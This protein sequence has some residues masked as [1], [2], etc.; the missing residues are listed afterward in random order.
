QTLGMR[1]RTSLALITALISASACNEAAETPAGANAV[2]KVSLRV[3]DPSDPAQAVIIQWH[4]SLLANDF[5]EFFEVEFRTPQVSDRMIRIL[6]DGIRER[7]VPPV[8]LSSEAPKGV[9][10]EGFRTY[11]LVGCIR[12]S[13]SSGPVRM[14]SVVTV[15]NIGGQWKVGGASFGAPSTEYDGPCPMQPFQKRE[16]EAAPASPHAQE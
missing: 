6:F 12:N 13:E 14:M 2:E 8:I 1:S 4:Q 3:L 11:G 7:G 10:P 5:Q 16:H 15:R 9:T